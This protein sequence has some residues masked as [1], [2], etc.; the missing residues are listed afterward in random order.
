MR[1]KDDIPMYNDSR[2]SFAV[3]IAT[4]WFAKLEEIE[5]TGKLEELKDLIKDKTL[6]GEY[7]GDDKFQHMVRYEKVTLLFYA[8][9]Q[10][11]SYKI[12][13]LPENTY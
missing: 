1:T 3:L 7:V 10:N 6:V 8:I 2:Y 4:V 5:K 11:N 13:E 12:C 9:V